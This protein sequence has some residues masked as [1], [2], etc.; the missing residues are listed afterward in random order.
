MDKLHLQEKLTE[1]NNKMFLQ[2]QTIESLFKELELSH[3]QNLISEG[4]I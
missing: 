1:Q 2:E 3:K 4:I